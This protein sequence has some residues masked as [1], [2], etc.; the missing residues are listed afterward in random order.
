MRHTRIALIAAALAA[1]TSG[2]VSSGLTSA[3]SRTGVIH[4]F[5][6]PPPHGPWNITVGPDG[7]MWFTIV[8]FCCDTPNF[9]IGMLT[10]SGQFTGFH[11]P[12]PPVSAGGIVAGPDGRLWFFEEGGASGIVAAMDTSGNVTE[13]P[14][15]PV[16][17]PDGS[18]AP[19]SPNALTLGPDG[20]L[21]FTANVES[22]CVQTGPAIGRVDVGG[23][24][25]EF[26]L[27]SSRSSAGAIIT[28]PDGA[29]WFT[30][31]GTSNIDRIT[32][33]G[34]LSSFPVPNASG[35]SEVA[36]LA[37]GPD[38]NIWFTDA[39]LNTI[40]RM[41]TSGKVT[42]FPMRSQ[43]PIPVEITAGPDGA[44]WFLEGNINAAGLGRITMQGKITEFFPPN[45]DDSG[46][47]GIS[48]G[49]PSMPHTVWFTQDR[50]NDID[51]ITTK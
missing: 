25:S 44:M 23:G 49:P 13:Y 26:L 9:D 2:V 17:L 6:L 33:A 8:T 43:N 34:S 39:G 20:A 38:G 51:F 10:P 12:T 37:K 3:A 16:Q 50:S 7:N 48:P 15:P 14:V 46:G 4:Q 11:V 31:P 32:T 42:V 1:L 45:P 21:W 5:N 19:V 22:C 35:F 27:P 40:N 36:F 29:L 47:G 24:F 18:T 28:G 41:T 30:D